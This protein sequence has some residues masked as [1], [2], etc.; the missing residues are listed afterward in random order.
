V[1]TKLKKCNHIP[2]HI[3]LLKNQLKKLI[4]L[5]FNIYFYVIASSV[6]LDNITR[7]LE[8]TTEFSFWIVYRVQ[9]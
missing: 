1:K 6:L 8:I 5:G 3:S 2:L 7:S 9:D 4:E